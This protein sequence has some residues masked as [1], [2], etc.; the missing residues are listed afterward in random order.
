MRTLGALGLLVV[1][2]W[3]LGACGD[4][5]PVP[6]PDSGGTGSAGKGSAGKGGRA[7]SGTGGGSGEGG[8]AAGGSGVGGTGTA[9]G[10]A[11]A[12]AEA[13]S[14]AT[15]GSGGTGVGGTGGDNQAGS[16]GATGGTAGRSAAGEA[17]AGGEAGGVPIG[18]NGPGECS[19]Y[20]TS[21][22]RAVVNDGADVGWAA[23]NLENGMVMFGCSGASSPRDCLSSLPL[24]SDVVSGGAWDTVSGS[25]S[26]VLFETTYNTAY[27]TATSPDGRFL[28]HGGV[29]TT[30]YGA[31]IV[32]L[33]RDLVVPADADYVPSFFPDGS[34]FLFAGTPD[35]TSICRQSLLTTGSPTS[36]TFTESGCSGTS[37]G[38]LAH[39]AVSSSAHWAQTGVFAPDDGNASS[40]PPIPFDSDTD[41][42]FIPLVDSGT[43]FVPGPTIDRIL[44]YVTNAVISPSARLVLGQ[45]GNAS[46]DA[47]GY[48][49]HRVDITEVGSTFSVALPEVA[50]YC[51]SGGTPAFSYDERFVVMHHRA[52][53]EDA[54][55]LGFSSAS[56][57][58]FAAYRG[59]ANLYLI[60]LRS[61]ER[62][63]LT[64]MPAGMDAVFPN[65]RSD[66]WIYFVVKDGTHPEYLV[67][68]DAAL[69]LAAD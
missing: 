64:Q 69:L 4:D 25:Y 42:Q 67:A 52:A 43:A 56:A 14:G 6:T 47:L 22:S 23:Q 2:A 17:G 20:T 45:V 55:D 58:A 51:F 10:D 63:R 29:S 11:G 9:G 62:T 40:D 48:V 8:D 60:D 49:L 41:I 46:S 27:W 26:R 36:I 5:D 66:G 37:I 39:L 24:A 50:R 31:S 61:G 28:A 3:G 7:G 34:G 35:G 57:P 13:G 59:T 19:S 18:G 21:S 44:P 30:G 32:D 38:L 68:T 12:G 15:G 65:F 53:D 54:V 1:S 33:E 16:G